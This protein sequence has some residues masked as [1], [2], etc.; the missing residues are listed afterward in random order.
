MNSKWH[1]EVLNVV[2]HQ[3]QEENLQLTRNANES[4]ENAS[5]SLKVLI[6]ISEDGDFILTEITLCDISPSNTIIQFYS[7]IATH[8]LDDCI[9][10]V[11]KS[12]I[13]MNM[14]TALGAF[15]I[16]Y[17]GHQI[18]HKYSYITFEQSAPSI[19]AQ[20][21][22]GITNLLL[23]VIQPSYMICRLLSEGSLS[24]DLAVSKGLI[25]A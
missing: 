15:G 3:L 13:H 9:P 1:N 25:Q 10:E 23:K 17:E 6:P 5:D 7:T 21:I 19:I 12:L 24:F 2:A 4:L 16:F 8:V 22:I 20:Q 14:H 18:Y 11:E